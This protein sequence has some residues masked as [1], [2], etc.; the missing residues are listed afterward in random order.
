M[1][2]ESIGAH[3]S[4]HNTPVTTWVAAVL[5]FFV[6][7]WLCMTLDF[8]LFSDEQDTSQPWI[9]ERAGEPALNTTHSLFEYRGEPLV[10]KIWVMLPQPLLLAMVGRVLCCPKVHDEFSPGRVVVPLSDPGPDPPSH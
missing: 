2:F 5:V 8:R 7:L 6:P 10:G 4:F 1:R 3:E 9:R